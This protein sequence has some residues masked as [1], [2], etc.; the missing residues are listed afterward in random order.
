[1]KFKFNR[2]LDM[3]PISFGNWPEEVDIENEEE[4]Q[5]VSERFASRIMMPHKL[6]I[7]NDQLKVKIISLDEYFK[8]DKHWEL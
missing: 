1:M 8:A 3:D 6:V 2:M 4:L 7:E 5:H